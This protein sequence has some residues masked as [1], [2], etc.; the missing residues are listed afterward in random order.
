MPGT[1]QSVI[2]RV[3]VDVNRQLEFAVAERGWM[4]APPVL[5]EP[6]QGEAGVWPATDQFLTELRA[7][8]KEHGLLLIVDEI[9]KPGHFELELLGLARNGYKS[10]DQ[11]RAAG[12]AAYLNEQFATPAA[13][14]VMGQPPWYQ[15]LTKD[16]TLEDITRR[17]ATVETWEALG[18]A[19][20]R[21]VLL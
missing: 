9:Q 19:P 17:A 10:A 20:R 11:A 5:L 1:L 3:D 8:T 2:I 13:H 16:N 4:V 6:I 14:V 15:N 21:R 12:I 7:L 18:K